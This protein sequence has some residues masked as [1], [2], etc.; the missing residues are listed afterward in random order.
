M[1]TTWLELS[2]DTGVSQLCVAVNKMDTIDWDESR[3]M[4]I[5]KKLGNFLKQTGFKEKDICYIPCSGLSG[6]NLTKPPTEPKLAD[7]YKGPTLVQQIGK[8]THLGMNQ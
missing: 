6:E 4:E 3:F 8:L 5:T 1:Y 2:S 7:W